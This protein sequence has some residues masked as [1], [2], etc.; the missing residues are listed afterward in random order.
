MGGAWFTLLLPFEC[1]RADFWI[2]FEYL[3]EVRDATLP[4]PE[5]C[6]FQF[7]AKK[8]FFNPAQGPVRN[9]T[10]ASASAMP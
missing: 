4:Q 1:L 10:C 6:F 2:D 9:L 5:A 3:I 8:V 7:F